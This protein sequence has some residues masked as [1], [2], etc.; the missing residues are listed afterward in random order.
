M[1]KFDNWQI[2][3][4]PDE[5]LEKLLTLT[6]QTKNEAHDLI[7]EIRAEGEGG[8]SSEEEKFYLCEELFYLLLEL[9]DYRRKSKKH[10]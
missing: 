1:V 10:D 8:A 7:S 4:V 5:R 9:R 6:Y 2:W 3:K